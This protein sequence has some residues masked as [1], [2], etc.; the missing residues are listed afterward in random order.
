MISISFQIG[1][2]AADSISSLSMTSERLADV[3]GGTIIDVPD[4]GWGRADCHKLGMTSA[5]DSHRALG[6]SVCQ[7]RVEHHL[8]VIPG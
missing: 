5:Q 7:E 2:D 3:P 4:K 1:C 8:R 6:T